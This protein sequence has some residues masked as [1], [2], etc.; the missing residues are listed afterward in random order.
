MPASFHHGKK[1]LIP[2]TGINLTTLLS[3]QGTTQ[4]GIQAGIGLIRSGDTPTGRSEYMHID[5]DT[6][7]LIISQIQ[8]ED[9]AF[10]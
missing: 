6:N 3:H 10:I 5:N 1:L 7:L 4:Y 2:A 9:T 8:Y